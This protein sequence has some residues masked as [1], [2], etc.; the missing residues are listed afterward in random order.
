MS[1][2]A[3]HYLQFSRPADAANQPAQP[4]A[5]WLAVA[6]AL[7]ALFGAGTL[8][9]LLLM[10]RP[11]ASAAP[12]HLGGLHTAA[13]APLDTQPIIE[14]RIEGFQAGFAA[15]IEQCGTPPPLPRLAYP[16]ATA[17]R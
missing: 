14:A 2:H 5:H 8:I 17:A 10:Q 7:I 13:L 1:P 4:P 15:G 12:V 6:V 16:I 9:A 3:Q 11:V